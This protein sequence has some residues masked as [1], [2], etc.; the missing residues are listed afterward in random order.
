M[1][2]KNKG[3]VLSNLCFLLV[4]VL[5]SSFMEANEELKKE[6]AEFKR[7]AK[8]G[9]NLI[10]NSCKNLKRTFIRENKEEVQEYYGRDSDVMYNMIK[11]LV[12]RCDESQEQ[13]KEFFDYIKSFPSKIGLNIDENCYD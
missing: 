9:F 3:L 1:E 11:L 10:L 8:R 2:N 12:D 6:N 5:E 13:S 7:E 4:D